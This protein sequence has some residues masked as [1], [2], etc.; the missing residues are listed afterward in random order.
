MLAKYLLV[1]QVFN[2]HGMKRCSFI[3]SEIW[4]TSII[5]LVS[6]EYSAVLGLLSLLERSNFI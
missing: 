5:N 6:L 2:T 3:K 4:D 1:I